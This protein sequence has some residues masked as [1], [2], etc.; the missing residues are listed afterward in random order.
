MTLEEPAL[1]GIVDLEN[2]RSA[3][4]VLIQGGQG[5]QAATKLSLFPLRA[6]AV[7]L[8]FGKKQIRPTL[9]GLH[10]CVAWTC[11]LVMFQRPNR[12]SHCIALEKENIR[13]LLPILDKLNKVTVLDFSL[14][15]LDGWASE[16]N[17]TVVLYTKTNMMLGT[18]F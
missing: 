18:L 7:P 14:T 6:V 3:L 15:S 1:L 4:D 11:S 8:T 13:E 12:Y 9:P 16:G 5:G 10:E 2:E 17:S